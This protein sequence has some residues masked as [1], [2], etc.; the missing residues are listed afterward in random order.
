[1]E[2][3]SVPGVYKRGGRYVVMFRDAAGRQRSRSAANLSEARVL[4]AELTADVSRGEYREQSRITFGDYADE[5]MRTYTGRT[6]RGIRPATMRGYCR[7]LRLHVLPV[8]GPRRLG[9]IEPRHVRLLAADLAAAGKSPATV[10]NIMAPVRAMFAT[11]VDDGLVRANPCAGLRLPGGGS[12]DRTARALTEDELQRLVAEVPEQWRLVV[13]FLSQTGLR[14]GELVPLRWSD[15]DLKAGRVRVV[16]RL[17][18][19]TLDTPKS[20]YGVRDV[21]LSTALVRDLKAHRKASAFAADSDLV[22]P[23]RD[24]TVLQPHNLLVRVVKPAGARAGVPWA[25]LH[26]LRHTCASR[27]FRSG[28]NAKQVQMVLGHHSPAFTLTTYVHLIPEDLPRPVFP[29]EPESGHA[30]RRPARRARAASPRT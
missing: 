23:S 12:V 18:R 3:T 28:W 22:F 30:A 16:R 4:K 13:R 2:K 29:D 17:Y 14:I 27:L 7:D 21:P 26:T 19:G 15:V 6:S 8:L 10:R 11:A 25:G 9:H 20:R 5:W 24:G 1:M